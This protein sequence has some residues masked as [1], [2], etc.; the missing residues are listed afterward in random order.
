MAQRT[1]ADSLRVV[2]AK[3]SVANQAD[4]DAVL[5]E[6]AAQSARDR[7]VAARSE[8]TLARHNVAID[9]DKVGGAAVGVN[10]E[11]KATLYQVAGNAPPASDY[12]EVPIATIDTV[13]ETI[14]EPPVEEPAPPAEPAALFRRRA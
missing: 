5:A 2:N 13:V 8:V 12:T 7:S 1:I 14:E 3:T 9:L 10:A 6:L 11:G 4:S